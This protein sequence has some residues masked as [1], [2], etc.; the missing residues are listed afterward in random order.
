[1]ETKTRNGLTII[2]SLI[3]GIVLGG[4]L[5]SQSQPRSILSL[6]HCTNCFSPSDLVGLVASVVI[7]K[8]PGLMPSVVVETDRTIVIK[9]PFP[10]VRVHYVVIPKKDIKNIGSMSDADM[11]YLSDAFS[12]IKEIINNEKLSNYWVYTNG[13]ELQKVTYLHFHLI[14]E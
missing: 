11:A 3:L 5:F 13:P 7:Q 1:M 14:S 9:H 4:Y 2:F 6:N 10:R 8:L 12:V